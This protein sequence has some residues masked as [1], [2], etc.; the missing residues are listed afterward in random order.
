MAISKGGRATGETPISVSMRGAGTGTVSV[1]VEINDT[2]CEQTFSAS[3]VSGR[4]RFL[5]RVPNGV[6]KLTLTSPPATV[7]SRFRVEPVRS[8]RPAL[9]LLCRQFARSVKLPL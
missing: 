3:L 9:P 6:R 7:S 8:R 4:G 1:A 5:A 2:L